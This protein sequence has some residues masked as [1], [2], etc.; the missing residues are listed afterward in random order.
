MERRVG[1]VGQAVV[2]GTG[3]ATQWRA[4]LLGCWHSDHRFLP[5]QQADQKGGLSWGAERGGERKRR[6]GRSGG[7]SDGRCRRWFSPIPL[8]PLFLTLLSGSDGD[9]LD[10]RSVNY[11]WRRSGSA[12]GGTEEWMK[13]GN[14]HMKL[15]K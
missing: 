10:C 1:Q 4:D 3:A 15:T 14:K 13:K 6:G 9:G 12:T 2:G 11:G 8:L 7:R 5:G